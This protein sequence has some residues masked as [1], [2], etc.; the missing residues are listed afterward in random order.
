MLNLDL[1]ELNLTKDIDLQ[2]LDVSKAVEQ[3]DLDIEDFAAILNQHLDAEQQITAEEL[4]EQPINLAAL[5]AKIDSHEIDG[6]DTEVLTTEEIVTPIGDETD[7]ESQDNDQSTLLMAKL[8]QDV[9]ELP[10]D[11]ELDPLSQMMPIK[12]DDTE[13]TAEE[14]A[15]QI[16]TEE[17]E[18]TEEH[19]ILE[20][21]A[22]LQT[23][24]ESQQSQQQA[25]VQPLYQPTASIIPDSR[26]ESAQED[27][28]IAKNLELADNSRNQQAAKSARPL[29]QQQAMTSE[30]NRNDL[31]IIEDDAELELDQKKVINLKDKR[32]HAQ[33]NAEQQWASKVTEKKALSEPVIP[34]INEETK[35]SKVELKQ[36][37]SH[38]SPQFTATVNQD[39]TAE[40]P[41]MMQLPQSV[42][43]NEWQPQL[44]Q[45]LVM[46]SHGGIKNA[47]ISLN[48]PELGPLNVKVNVDDDKVKVVFNSTHHLTKEA[49]ETAVPKLKE[50]FEAEGMELVQVDVQ[51][52]SQ[53]DNSNEQYSNSA[54]GYPASISGGSSDES[55]EQESVK[56][57]VGLVDFYA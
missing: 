53:Q 47:M 40:T 13:L 28:D 7:Q 36:N 18:E 56:K 31:P 21:H 12:A 3:L 51:F 14:E 1:L 20:D 10:Q 46:M 11:S 15:G 39:K 27:N 32:E 34:L 54:R 52:T 55:V 2:N 43:Q 57:V 37:I 9:S 50:M 25:D 33:V 44:G 22:D 49:I 38:M 5:M 26:A 35:K 6:D 17:A 45:K 29:T 48:P 41:K 24:H 30:E 19:V 16:N 8:F 42:L 4:T 23:E